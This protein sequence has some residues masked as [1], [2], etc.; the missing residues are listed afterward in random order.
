MHNG[1]SALQL[2]RLLTLPCTKVA[3]HQSAARWPMKARAPA[4]KPH[5]TMSGH[6]AIASALR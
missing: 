1:L 5:R 4:Q 3:P 6:I 2:A